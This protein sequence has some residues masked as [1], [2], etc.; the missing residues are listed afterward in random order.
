MRVNQPPEIQ[1]HFMAFGTDWLEH[2]GDDGYK[3]VH[4]TV[5]NGDFNRDAENQMTLKV[6]DLN[7]DIPALAYG[8]LVVFS[9]LNKTAIRK[10]V[11]VGIEFMMRAGQLSIQD[12]HE[13]PQEAPEEADQETGS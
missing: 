4:V 10:A 5:D 2:V 13:Q 1:L 12:L 7:A 6:N 8:G 9:N 3:I 11:M